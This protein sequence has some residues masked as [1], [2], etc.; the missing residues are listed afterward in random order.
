MQSRLIRSVSDPGDSR[1][2]GRATSYAQNNLKQRP[3]DKQTNTVNRVGTGYSS[4]E[5]ADVD[6]KA[7]F[8]SFDKIL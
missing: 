1:P 7:K 2:I 5:P 3:L 4:G 6:L 8:G